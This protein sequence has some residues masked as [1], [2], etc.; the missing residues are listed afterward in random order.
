MI[1]ALILIAILL[2]GFFGLMSLIV[3]L[4][5]FMLERELDQFDKEN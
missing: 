3:F 1:E 4:A 2:I 5:A